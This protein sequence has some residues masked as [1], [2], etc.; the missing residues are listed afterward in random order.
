MQNFYCH[1]LMMCFNYIH[2]RDFYC[3]RLTY[4]ICYKD[5]E[6]IE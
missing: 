6:G 5:P 1:R 3:K 2:L 4:E